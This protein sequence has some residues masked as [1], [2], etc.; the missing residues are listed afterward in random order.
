[1]PD[2]KLRTETRR[3]TQDSPI[4]L[5]QISGN[6]SSM[7]SSWTNDLYLVSPE[8]SDGTEIE[9]ASRSFNRLARTPKR[10]PELCKLFPHPELS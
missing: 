10:H 7:A 4:T 1:M 5:F 6:A 8:Q 9:L 3:L 2:E